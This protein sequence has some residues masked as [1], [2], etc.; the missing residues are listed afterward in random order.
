MCDFGQKRRDEAVR[1]KSD[2]YF[3]RVLIAT[4]SHEAAQRKFSCLFVP[5][6]GHEI[7]H[8]QLGH[9]KKPLHLVPQTIF[10]RRL[11]RAQKIFWNRASG[12]NLNAI[13]IFAHDCAKRS[14]CF[15]KQL[16][17][18]PLTAPLAGVKSATRIDRSPVG[19]RHKTNET[20]AVRLTAE[21]T[22]AAHC[23]AG[24]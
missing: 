11:F 23:S 4:K 24:Q 6:C 14:T 1:A 5:F 19:S 16:A 12:R 9:A 7:S 21:F 2:A 22:F 8:R 15:P 10:A 17:K 20:I 18:T 13:R 3:M